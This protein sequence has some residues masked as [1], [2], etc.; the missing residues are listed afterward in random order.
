MSTKGIS[1]GLLSPSRKNLTLNSTGGRSSS[2]R[3]FLKQEASEEDKQ[4]AMRD[5]LNNRAS[6]QN[7]SPEQFKMIRMGSSTHLVPLSPTD[8]STDA[9]IPAEGESKKAMARNLSSRVVDLNDKSDNSADQARRAVEK[10]GAAIASNDFLGAKKSSSIRYRKMLAAE[11]PEPPMYMVEFGRGWAEDIFALLQNSIRR[12]VQDLYYIVNSMKKR[13]VDL[14]KQDVTDFYEW[15]SFFALLLD[16]VFQFEDK[17]LM[18]WVEERVNLEG[19][20]STASRNV[21]KGKVMTA[22]EQI[23]D[24]QFKFEHLPPGEV[25][26]T[27]EKMLEVLS[28]GLLE[29]FRLEEKHIIPAVKEAFSAKD[30]EAFEVKMFETIRGMDESHTVMAMLMRSVKNED[31]LR[32][33]QAKYLRVDGAGFFKT[34]RFKKDYFASKKEFHHTHTRLVYV[35][36]NRWN[37]AHIGAED[38]EWNR[39]AGRVG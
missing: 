39:Q 35:F 10:D 19:D 18:P 31:R 5:Q 17:S 37:Q 21:R 11:L 9:K 34:V 30:G 1:A 27:V 28:N 12:E 6:A 4:Q 15:L 3:A 32:D 26:P 14:S 25:L 16:F 7:L 20:L 13:S 33:Y 8:S 29:Q 36:F 38:D 23:E 24:C 2:L 22:I